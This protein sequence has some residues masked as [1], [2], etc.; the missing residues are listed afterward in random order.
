MTT[1]VLTLL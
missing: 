1:Y